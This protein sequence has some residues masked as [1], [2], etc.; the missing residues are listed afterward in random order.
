MAWD[1]RSITE[2]NREAG[3]GSEDIRDKVFLGGKM[4]LRQGNQGNIEMRLENGVHVE[5]IRSKKK[6]K[7]RRGNRNIPQSLAS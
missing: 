5:D 3:M 7:R 2:G 1:E 4:M 6:A